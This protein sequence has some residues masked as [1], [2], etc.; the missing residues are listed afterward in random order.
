MSL[1]RCAPGQWVPAQE[2][3]VRGAGASGTGRRCGDTLLAPSVTR[4]VI[5]NYA[6]KPAP[7]GYQAELGRLTEREKEVL[8]L[9][10]TAKATQSSGPPCTWARARSKHVSKVLTKLGLR[11]RVQAVIF[12]YEGGLIERG[13]TSAQ[14]LGGLARSHPAGSGVSLAHIGLHIV[15]FLKGSPGEPSGYD[16]QPVGGQPVGE[17]RRDSGTGVHADAGQAR[18]QG[19]LDGAKAARSG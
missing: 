19:R 5:E 1:M 12:A 17:H 16:R 11:D 6:Q 14:G 15:L 10:G 9:L 13:R 7:R 3:A 2:R 4:N 18:H 8:R